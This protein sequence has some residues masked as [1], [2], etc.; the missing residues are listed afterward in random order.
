[1]IIHK[2]GVNE[3]HVMTAK[4]PLVRY[5]KLRVAHA[6]GMPIRDPDTCCDDHACAV[7]HAE[8]SNRIPLKSMAGKTLPAFP[9]HEQPTV[10]RIWQG[11][12]AQQPLLVTRIDFTL[13]LL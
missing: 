2:Q 11:A 13:H 7:M 4:G 1:M 9:T 5:V 10:L 3:V 8:I 6:S 12:N